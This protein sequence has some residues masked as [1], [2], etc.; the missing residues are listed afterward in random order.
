MAAVKYNK[1]WEQIFESMGQQDLPLFKRVATK[2]LNFDMR[3]RYC[4]SKTKTVLVISGL[5]KIVNENNT[6]EEGREQIKISD[7]DG[8]KCATMYFVPADH[9]KP[10]RKTY[11]LGIKCG[12]GALIDYTSGHES[13]SFRYSEKDGVSKIVKHAEKEDKKPAE[14]IES[15]D[16]KKKS[17]REKRGDG[18]SCWFRR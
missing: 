7:V 5:T 6:P 15:V 16:K 18:D 3:K 1:E 11:A 13:Y 14:V 4:G 17:K 8:F 9:E 10:T 12:V 2:A